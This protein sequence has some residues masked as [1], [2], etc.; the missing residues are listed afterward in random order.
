MRA[1]RALGYRES[2]A[3]ESENRFGLSEK[4]IL[5]LWAGQEGEVL[6][7]TRLLRKALCGPQLTF[8]FLASGPAHFCFSSTLAPSYCPT[9]P[10]SNRGMVVRWLVG[11]GDRCLNCQCP[12][13]RCLGS[14]Q[15]DTRNRSLWGFSQVTRLK[16]FDLLRPMSVVPF[17]V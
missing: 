5:G 10:T 14:K 8:V 11:W 2:Q 9:Y 7:P 16:H 13:C 3:G 15:S 12:L 1:P 17:Q 6:L 4:L